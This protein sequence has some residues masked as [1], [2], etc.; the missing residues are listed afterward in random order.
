LLSGLDL[1]PGATTILALVTSPAAERWSSALAGWAIPDEIL[2]QAPQS[3]WGFP[4]SLFAVHPARKGALHRLAIDGLGS[5]LTVLDVGCGGGAASIPLAPRAGHLIGVDSSDA[6]LQSFASAAETAGVAHTEVLGRWPDV[7]SDVPRVAVCRNV[8][9]N[10]ADIGPFLTTLSNHV[11]HRVVVELTDLHPSVALAPLWQ[12][13]WGLRR[14]DGPSAGLFAEVVADLGYKAAVESELR[15][16]DKSAS[17]D[18]DYVTFVRR[19]LCLSSSYDP[20]LA[21]ALGR[22]DATTRSLVLAWPP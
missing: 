21:E 11:K 14:P 19:R 3:P 9:Y 18:T 5:G 1:Q 16:A 10:V 15:P 2:A 22:T 17:A 12:R 7:A 13:F 6:M 4:A 8:V 20:E